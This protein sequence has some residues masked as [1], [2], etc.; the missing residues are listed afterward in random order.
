MARSSS[1][2]RI[3]TA[4]TSIGTA[5]S[6]G[7]HGRP[8]IAVTLQYRTSSVGGGKSSQTFSLICVGWWTPYL[9]GPMTR[10]NDPRYSERVDL[11]LVFT[12]EA[13]RTHFRK[14]S[15]VP[16]LG[17]L[18]AVAA[19]VADH[20]GDEDQIIAAL[21]HDYLEDVE[22]SAESALEQRFGARVT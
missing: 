12:A 18:L 21:L 2:I 4:G 11:A 6:S 15:G 5:A 10:G 1:T 8:R 22:G 7:R 19:L 3:R 20:G 16:Y 17:H 9:V 14:G 13:F